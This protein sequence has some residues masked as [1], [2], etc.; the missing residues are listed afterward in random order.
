MQNRITE[1]LIKQQSLFTLPTVIIHVFKGDPFENQFFKRAF[2]HG[3]K[4]KTENC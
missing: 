4:R 2:E 3:I 1:T